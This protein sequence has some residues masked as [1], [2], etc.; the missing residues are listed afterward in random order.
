MIFI[1]AEQMEQ[2]PGWGTPWVAPQV[3][4]PCVKEI[5]PSLP[6]K[7]LSGTDLSTSIAL[8]G[9]QSYYLAPWVFSGSVSSC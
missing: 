9:P 5:V 4:E 8:S 3:Y 1:R 7:T 6:N 2:Q